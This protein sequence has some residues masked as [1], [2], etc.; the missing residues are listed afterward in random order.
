MFDL[1]GKFKPEFVDRY[2]GM[3]NFEKYRKLVSKANVDM[4]LGRF[5]PFN[6]VKHLKAPTKTI[7]SIDGTNIQ[8][9]TQPVVYAGQKNNKIFVNND[10]MEKHLE[11]FLQHS[12]YV[13]NQRQEH[14]LISFKK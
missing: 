12:L 11:Q 9:T 5:A 10:F 7:V 14:S 13:F 1:F 2:S 8:N 3:S 6:K 4:V